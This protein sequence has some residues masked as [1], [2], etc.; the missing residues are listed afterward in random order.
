MVDFG[1]NLDD[2]L[3][4]L[5]IQYGYIGMFMS[6]FP[7]A[8]TWGFLANVVIVGLTAASYTKIARRSLSAQQESLGVWIDIFM[9]ISFISTV[10]N[11]MI[12]AYTSNAL[13]SFYKISDKSQVLLI[14]VFAEHI[15]IISKYLID[16][17]V[18]EIQ[19]EIRDKVSEE[20]YLKQQVAQLKI[21][22]A[23]EKVEEIVNNDVCDINTDLMNMLKENNLMESVKKV[24]PLDQ[25]MKIANNDKLS[26]PE[27]AT[28]KQKRHKQVVESETEVE[29]SDISEEE[30][31]IMDSKLL[32]KFKM[33]GFN[34]TQTN[35]KNNSVMPSLPFLGQSNLKSEPP[36]KKEDKQ[37]SEIKD[38]NTDQKS[39]D[40]IIKEKK[41]NTATQRNR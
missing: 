24:V 20:H 19:S 14:A 36:Q 25:L 38:E 7:A 18:P 2:Y 3:M 40:R 16:K 27:D 8:S 13:E 9:T 41:L 4:N 1:P 31:F 28:L 34:Q 37:Y 26:K 30:N 21:K 11:A 32:S 17:L 15:I 5:A 12:V 33:E 39:D 29:E 6:V 10:V 22:E 35:L 23:Q